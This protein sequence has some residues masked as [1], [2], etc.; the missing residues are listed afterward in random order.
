MYHETQREI[1]HASRTDIQIKK[2]LRVYLQLPCIFLLRK[3]APKKLEKYIWY[4]GV[5]AG[6]MSLNSK[7]KVQIAFLL[8]R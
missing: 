5:H 7:V 3:H 2:L 6:K 1:F 8:L 4:S